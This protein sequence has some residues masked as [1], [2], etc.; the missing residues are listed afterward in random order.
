MMLLIEIFLRVGLL[1][2]FIYTIKTT[3]KDI[4]NLFK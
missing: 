3:K 4:K 2:T 1:I